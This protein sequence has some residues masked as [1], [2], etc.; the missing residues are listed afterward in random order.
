MSS[1]GRRSGRPAA[2]LEA[3]APEIAAAVGASRARF[4]R[5]L[6]SLWSGYGEL[7][8]VTLDGATP[9]GA[10]SAG[11][12][13]APP[14]SVIVKWVAPPPDE[15]GRSHARKLRSYDVELRWYRAYA[16]ACDAACRVPVAWHCS[17]R[18]GRWLFVLED[19]DAAGFSERRSHLRAP[20]VESCLR[21]LAHFHARFLGRPPEGLWSVGTYWHLATRPDELVALADRRLR[22]AAPLLDARLRSARYQTFVH[23]DAKVENF[24][25]AGGSRSTAQPVT[26]QPVAAVDF[27][28]VGGGPGIK[29][30]AYFLSSC[31]TPRECEHSAERHLASYFRELRAALAA[32]RPDID[33]GEV[34]AEWRELFPLAW[35]DF[36]RFL[37]GWAPGAYEL[38]PYSRELTAQALRT[39][40]SAAQT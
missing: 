3:A 12:S 4:T 17:A 2:D 16:A 28:Y 7:W 19:L 18:G 11:T 34:E 8:R 14:P 39:L 27:Q 26:T 24:C 38:D 29:D 23:G 15:R 5:R 20:E 1:A 9:D 6:Q 37:L 21:W 36:Y 25:F 40:A 22:E 32:H 35:A 10:Q 31:L 13:N 33:G 30:V